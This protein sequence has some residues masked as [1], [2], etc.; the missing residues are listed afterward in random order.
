M[1]SYCKSIVGSSGVNG[2]KCFIS[3]NKSVFAVADGASGAKDKAYASLCCIKTLEELQFNSSETSPAEYIKYSINQAN[4]Y[5]IQKS[6]ADGK[7]SFGTFTLSVY[8]DGILYT[9]AV[10][11]TPAFL[12]R[13]ESIIQLVKPK[14]RYSNTVEHGVITEEEA[15]RAAK[16]LPGP[17]QSSFEYFLPMI[18]PDIALSNIQVNSGDVLIICCDGISDWVKPEEMRLIL[19][20]HQLFKDACEEIMNKSEIN[21]RENYLDDRTIV[22]VRF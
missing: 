3:G 20:K 18:I 7:L 2:D 17:L 13:K 16:S 15:E 10:G 5:L 11:D 4:K 6:Q 8:N 14:K 12:F 9:G 1:E 21:C 19:M 22:A